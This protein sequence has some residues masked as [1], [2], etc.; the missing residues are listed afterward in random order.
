MA[1]KLPKIKLPP[2]KINL[3][4]EPEKVAKLAEDLVL[5]ADKEITGPGAGGRK[6]QAVAD[7]LN[8]AVDVPVLPEW[9]ERVLFRAVAQLAYGF[10]KE[11]LKTMRR[12]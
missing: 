3:F 9:A 11:K 10:A 8:K 7:M 5:G 4:R 6:L 1:I 2:I 12:G